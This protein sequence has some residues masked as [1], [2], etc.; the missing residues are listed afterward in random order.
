[1]QKPSDY[2]KTVVH[3]SPTITVWGYPSLR[4]VHHQ[5]HGACSGEDF[6]NGL[7][8]GSRILRQLSG[9]GW[10]SDDR[11]NPIV[12]FEDEQWAQRVWFPNT[13]AAGWDCWAVVK[14][15]TLVGDLSITRF[16]E[17][18]ERMGMAT[19]CFGNVEPALEW[20]IQAVAIKDAEKKRS[21]R[22]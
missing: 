2:H 10:L 5:M 9:R 4:I 19:K 6:R 22:P 1:V 15:E 8:A 20:L 17:S 21:V 16:V 7:L 13:R 12:Q 3:Q 18:C 14:P 11:A